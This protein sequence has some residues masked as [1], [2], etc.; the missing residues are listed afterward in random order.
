MSTNKTTTQDTPAAEASTSVASASA[1]T[2]TE[3]PTPLQIGLGL[4]IVGASAG[5]TLYTK[6][7][8]QMLTQLKKADINKKQRL[9]KAKFGPT[10]RVQEDMMKNRWSKDDL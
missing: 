6:K 7:T 1:S 10:S 2:A 9:P 3:G 4:I 5:L 8:G